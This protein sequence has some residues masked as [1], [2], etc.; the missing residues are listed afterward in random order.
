MNLISDSMSV[1]TDLERMLPHRQFGQSEGTFPNHRPYSLYELPDDYI[2]QTELRLFDDGTSENKQ[3]TSDLISN[4]TKFEQL[5]RLHEMYKT[6]LAR[7]N[8]TKT[9]SSTLSPSLQYRPP[10]RC[11][12]LSMSDMLYGSGNPD[13]SYTGTG[14]GTGG[15]SIYSEPAYN[16]H[17]SLHQN[18]AKI[19]DNCKMSFGHMGNGSSWYQPLL[20]KTT[21]ENI[22]MHRPLGSMLCD[23][24]SHRFCSKYLF[25]FVVCHYYISSS[26]DVFLDYDDV[27]ACR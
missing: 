14:A 16:L 2:G 19:C 23:S 26:V 10:S 7:A 4:Q 8:V 12:S 11:Q 22:P 13:N 20:S 6:K 25:I 17:R 15:G 18:Q 3:R 5:A 1:V 9:L 27:C 21:R 24:I